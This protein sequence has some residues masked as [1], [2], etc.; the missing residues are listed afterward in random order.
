MFVAWLDARCSTG[1]LR[2]DWI[3]G[4]LLDDCRLKKEVRVSVGGAECQLQML[5]HISPGFFFQKNCH[6]T[7][8]RALSIN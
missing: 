8:S 4:M 5:R 7:A 6:G 3:L 2:P 1:S